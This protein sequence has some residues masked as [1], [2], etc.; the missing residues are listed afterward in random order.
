MLVDLKLSRLSDVWLVTNALQCVLLW[1]SVLLWR[2]SLLLFSVG[3]CIKKLLSIESL[4]IG[5]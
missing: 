5:T 1:S 2:D 3:F 4:R